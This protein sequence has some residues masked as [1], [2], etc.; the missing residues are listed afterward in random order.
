MGDKSPRH[1]EKKKQKADKKKGV[2]KHNT[3]KPSLIEKEK[4]SE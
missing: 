4:K 1:R 2:P 3:A